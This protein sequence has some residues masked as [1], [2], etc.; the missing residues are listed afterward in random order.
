[1]IDKVYIDNFKGLKK[2]DV[3]FGSVITVLIGK[4]SSGKSSLSQF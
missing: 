2:C 1:M 3:R 4:N